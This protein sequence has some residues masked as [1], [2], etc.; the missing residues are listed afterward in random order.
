MPDCRFTSTRRR[1]LHALLD[2]AV[3]PVGIDAEIA[4]S[5][6]A[7]W[8]GS[9]S[10]RSSHRD[11]G[12]DR[13]TRPAASSSGSGFTDERQRGRAA[14]PS[15]PAGRRSSVSAPPLRQRAARSC[16]R[17]DQRVGWLD[18]QRVVLVEQSMSPGPLTVSHDACN[19]RR[20]TGHG[21]WN[22]RARAGGADIELAGSSVASGIDAGR[23][24]RCRACSRR[25]APSALTMSKRSRDCR[26]RR[27]S[28]AACRRPRRDRA[29]S[30]PSRHGRPWSCVHATAITRTVPLKAGMSK[31][32]V[33]RAVRRRP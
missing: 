19:A 1:R 4:Q 24:S 10:V 3:Q 32:T 21:D 25:P 7:A 12:R 13:C 6:A 27:G 18:A 23:R 17:G 33:G 26:R 8:R 16:A 5:R 14:A 20:A 11:S 30:R 9:P 2:A 15:R 22:G 29:R 31:S 28:A